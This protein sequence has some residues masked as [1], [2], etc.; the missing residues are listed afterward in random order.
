M[1]SFDSLINSIGDEND[2][3][4]SVLWLQLL[5]STID[6]RYI[7]D[8]VTPAEALQ[9][10]KEGQTGKPKRIDELINVGYPCYTTQVGAL[11]CNWTIENFSLNFKAN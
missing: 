1:F 6:F 9:M 3:E 10:L 5:I 4:C 8:A 11:F 7:S 2:I